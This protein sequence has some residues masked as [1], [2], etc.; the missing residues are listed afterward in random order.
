MSKDDQNTTSFGF[1]MANWAGPDFWCVYANGYKRASELL[2]E[3]PKNTYETNTVIFPI[4]A[5]YRQYIELS[6]KEIIAYGQYLA[7]D[8]TMPMT[9]DL[10]NLWACG[11]KYLLR[12]YDTF[13]EDRLSR[14]QRLIHEI[15]EFDPTAEGTRYPKVKPKGKRG[16]ENMTSAINLPA[17]LSLDELHRHIQEL[18]ELLNEA[19][20]Y[21]AHSQDLEAEVRSIYQSY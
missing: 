15:H 1:A 18:G 5:L 14:A 8:G 7:A 13:G 17:F 19:T 12:Y 4:L 10:K 2:I 6:L 9:H 16:K 11:K 21:L 3:A 20:N